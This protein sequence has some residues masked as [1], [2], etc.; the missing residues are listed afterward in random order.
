[1]LSKGIVGEQQSLLRTV[2]NHA[3]RPM[4]HGRRNKL[5]GALADIQRITC[6]D[7]LIRIFAIMGF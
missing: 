2:G 3:V 7:A 6:F 1:M 4:E 5:Q